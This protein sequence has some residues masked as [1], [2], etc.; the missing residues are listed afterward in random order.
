[1]VA[2][3]G[4]SA[5]DVGEAA[6]IPSQGVA[7]QRPVEREMAEPL[8]TRRVAVVISTYWNTRHSTLTGSWSAVF[9]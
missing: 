7:W 3:W 4:E 6:S 1:M 2:E 9:Q 8:K 5:D